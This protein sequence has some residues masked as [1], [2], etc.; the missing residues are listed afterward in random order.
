M[1]KPLPTTAA[2]LRAIKRHVWLGHHGFLTTCAPG[3]EALVAQEVA[4]LPDVATVET[5]TGAVTFEAPFDTV[6]PALLRLRVADSLRIF[7]ARDL[8]AGSFPMLFDQLRRV[9]W[10]LWLPDACFVT[11]RVRSSKSRLRDDE[12]LERTLRRALHAAGVDASAGATGSAGAAGSGARDADAPP[13]ITLH[14]H[15][16][17]DRASVTLDAGGALHRRQGDKWVSQTTIRETTAAALV[18]LAGVTDPLHEPDLLVDPF[19]GSGTLVIEAL[20]ALSGAAA[21]RVRGS[22]A[23]AVPLAASPAW[24][25]ERWAHARRLY[26]GTG[27]LAETPVVLASDSDPSAVRAANHNLAARGYAERARTEV[28]TAQS[29]DLGAIA[30]THGARRPLLLTNPPYGRLA[31]A[32]GAAPGELLRALLSRAEGWRFALLYPHPQDLE[33]FPDVE[34]LEV[35]TVVTGG[36]RNALL[37]GRVGGRGR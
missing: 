14:L 16:N 5:R 32:R 8:A 6:Y 18:H 13:P 9:R 17:H 4:R 34:L 23:L 11:V 27:A 30:A 10:A 35:R 21:G 3:L 29:L 24:K 12:G 36:L 26:G 2:R 20:D 33:G 25:P 22:D 28:A 31:A 1:P 19:C 37:I 7:V 15:L